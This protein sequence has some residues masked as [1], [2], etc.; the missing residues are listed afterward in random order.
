[1]GNPHWA[2]QIQGC[3]TQT[4]EC[5]NH[6][7][8]G[9]YHI[10]INENYLGNPDAW[11]WSFVVSGEPT[12][13]FSDNANNSFF[14]S[15]SVSSF[16]QED[17]DIVYITTD[18][19][20]VGEFD[21]STGNF[22]TIL[23]DPCESFDFNNYPS[24]SKDIYTIKSLYRGQE[25]ENPVNVTETSNNSQA[26]PGDYEIWTLK[27]DLLIHTSG[28]QTMVYLSCIKLQI[29]IFVRRNQIAQIVI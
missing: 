1:M 18:L 22:E 25:W 27:K 16:S 19:A 17:T 13:I 15:N 3:S 23:N 2:L 10:T 28:L 26:C 20:S 24:W 14:E 29:G 8:S 5:Y 21:S 7:N 11:Q 12:W 9:I 4:G 6:T